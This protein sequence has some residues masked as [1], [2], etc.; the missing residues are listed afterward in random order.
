MGDRGNEPRSPGCEAK[1]LPLSYPAFV[2]SE[3]QNCY[4]YVT[5]IY[6]GIFWQSTK[7]NRLENNRFQKQ[8]MSI[9]NRF[10]KTTYFKTTNFKKQQILKTTD[11]NNIIFPKTTD[12]KKQ[13]ISK[14][15]KFQK[16]TNIKKQCLTAIKKGTEKTTD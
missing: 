9:N 8:H 6:F 11:F 5:Q 2:E 13:Q 3:G 10:Q 12:S 16:T 15:N 7:G 4:L 1:T 14:N